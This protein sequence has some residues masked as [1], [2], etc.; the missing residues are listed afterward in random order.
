MKV[1]KVTIKNIGPIESMELVF[2]KAL[3]L[4]YGEIRQGK[5]T[6]LNAIR[7]CFG[8]SFPEDIIRH[9]EKEGS[10]EIE[11]DC[12][13]ITRSWYRAKSGE[14]KARDILFI[15]DGRPVPK[16]AREIERFLNPFLLDQDYLRKMGETERKRYFSEIFA[17]DTTALD[18]E[19]VRLT[20][21][22]QGLRTTIASY[23]D[24]DLTPVPE[25]NTAALREKYEA[26]RRRH[27]AVAIDW[28]TEAEKLRADHES[29]CRKIEEENR[30]A[31]DQNSNREAARNNLH[32]IEQEIR[33]LKEKLAECEANHA[34]L[35]K[36]VA[37][38]PALVLR[39]KPSPPPQIAELKSKVQNHPVASDAMRALEQQ[40]SEA[41]AN[42]VRREQL[43]KNQERADKKAADEANLKGI[44][45]RLK[46]IKGEKIAK[47]KGVSETCGIKELSFDET[48]NFNYMGTDAGMLSTSQI[49]RLSS[50]L[51]ALYPEGI[52]LDLIDRGE[53]LGKSIFEFIDRAKEEEKTILATIVGDAPARVPSEIGVFV[54]EKGKATRKNAEEEPKLL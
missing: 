44:E 34:R 30:H 17:V 8:G 25:T 29:A 32:T 50:E 41:A 23:G 2:D 11:L 19:A 43:R 13:M 5:T 18:T 26:E 10:V 39:D 35:T 31:T 53:S 9:G 4:F 20:T 54:V 40:I 49:M 7:W 22:A 24:I 42:D 15:K 36:F 16:P 6:I 46:E 51:S 12:G 14:T 3:M 45:Q 1:K 33:V 28:S 21:Q 47:L 37:D 27:V 52:G 38:N 48:G